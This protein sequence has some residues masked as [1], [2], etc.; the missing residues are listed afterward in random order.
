MANLS[1]ILTDPNYVNANEATKQAIFDKFSAQDTNFTNA[2]ADTQA[3]I[4][5]RFGVAGAAPAPTTPSEIPAPR[6]G[7]TPYSVAPSN[8]TLKALISP[9]VGAYRGLQDITDTAYIAA[10][11]ALGVKGA[12]EESARQKAEFEQQYGGIAGAE[13]G[14][15]G[16]QIVGTLPI[17][18]LIAEPVKKLAVLA[19]SLAKF[20][21]PVAK[22]I[23]T[24]GFQT[25]LKP[26]VANLA[27]RAVGGGVVGGAAAGMVN[28]E[29]AEMGA[30][31]GAAIPAVALPV[32]KSGVNFARKLK[33]IKSA[34]YLDA[35]EGKGRDIVNALTSRTATI[36]PGS[37]P[38]AGEVAATAG[39]AKF[40]AFQKNLSKVPEIASEYAGAAA[41]TN[42]A[43]LAQDAR[44]Q[45]R[46]QN[47]IDKAQAKI[48]RNLV[49][50]SPSEIGDA[51]TAAANIERQAVKTNVVQPAYKAAFDAAGDAKIDVTDL[52]AQAEKILDR[53]LSTFATETAPDTV[54][55]LRGFVPVVPEAE[56]AA[57]GKMGFKTAKPPAPAALPPQ[58]T[59]QDLD[60]VR[61]AINADIA[62]ASTSNAPMAPTT[63]R[64]LRQ[65]H[66]AIDDAIGK[67]AA[68]TD[69]AKT[70][71]ADA[72]AKYRTEY[73]PRFKEGV[74]A[75]LF[76]RTSLG[77]DK[78]RPE[79]I[80]TRY[81]TPNGESEARQFAQ[82]FGN[83]P[84]ALRIARTGI[85]DVYR[86]KVAQGGMSHAN[87]L[88]DYGR[89]IDIYDNAGMNLRQRFDIINKDT[90][91]LAKIEDMAKASGNKLGPALPPGSN[92]LAVEQKITDLTRGLDNRQLTA[93]NSVREDIARE[94]EFERLATAG[95]KGKDTIA[96]AVKT[97]KETGIAP[98]Q[99]FL[100]TPV[101]IYNA[102]VKRLLG[103]VDN[104]LAMELA[105]EMLNPAVAAESIKKALA[106]QSEQ[107]L[108]NQLAQRFATRAAPGAAQMPANENQNALAR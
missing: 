9:V 62:A 33:D 75:N 17:G 12:R 37:A 25:G 93:V 26:G 71:Y 32:V 94:L 15:V 55:K 18:G 31:I 72:V 68:I 4:R 58:A 77:E 53:K 54:R 82:L 64:N 38:T 48:D 80:I 57:I 90:Q 81:F 49:D 106:R 91:R 13:V 29:D 41:Q 103:H 60:D 46:Y 1:S 99:A 61:K 66:A 76:K 69:D 19:P 85:E 83:N 92:A 50:V 100:S 107:A 30:A 74:N 23:E 35:V 39:S 65:L 86:K 3:A 97:G 95:G 56:A 47:V 44:V 70:L 63:L 10:T 73:A 21:T 11:E 34:A 96:G 24:A 101:T 88:K 104:K 20:L 59:L 98:T 67:S 7:A 43:R 42:Q 6:K 84:D 5:Q 108:T 87:F 36:V 79:D 105:R 2:N 52:V 22:S 27:T 78:I 89:T 16:G 28:P 51:L 14:R 102:V 45:Q 8:P 40:S